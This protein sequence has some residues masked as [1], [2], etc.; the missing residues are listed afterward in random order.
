MSGKELSTLPPAFDPRT[1]IHDFGGQRHWQMSAAEAFALQGILNRQEVELSLEIGTLEGGSLQVLSRYSRSVV[2]L[3][4]NPAVAGRLAGQFSNVRFLT[5]DSKRIIPD[6][7]SEIN[8]GPEKLGFVLIDGDH[9]CEGVRADINNLLAVVPKCMV[10]F[11]MHDSFNPDCREGMRKA[12]WEACPYVHYLELD[13]IPGRYYGEAVDTA[14]ARSMWAG[15]A[16]AVLLPEKR[17]FPL[18]IGESQRDLQRLLF[19]LSVHSRKPSRLRRWAGKL[20]REFLAFG[21]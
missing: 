19:P 14:Q 17:T 4:I 16:C 2:S 12:N 6:L 7:I 1:L 18:K 8:A 11:I 10:V 13:F 15:L 3:D 20:R 9:S 5:G 21:H